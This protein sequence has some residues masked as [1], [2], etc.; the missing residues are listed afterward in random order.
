MRASAVV[1]CQLTWRWSV[2]VAC[3]QAVSS[4]LR[5]LMSVMRRSRH[6]RVRADSSISAMLSERGVE[7][8]DAVG[9]EV[10]HHQYDGLGVGVVVGEQVVHLTSPVDLGSVRLGVDAAPATQG[11]TQTKIEQ[12]PWRTYSLSSFRS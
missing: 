1:N 6:S 9:V 4:V 5:V 8:A 2:L 10:V 11:S 7:R 12:V 3:C